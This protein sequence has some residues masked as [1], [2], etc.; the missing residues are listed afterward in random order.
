MATIIVAVILI[1]IITII[2]V[3]LVFIHKRDSRKKAFDLLGQ[4]RKMKSEHDLSFSHQEVLENHII[5]L[6][7]RK[8]K[9]LILGRREPDKYDSYVIDI[10]RLSGCTIRNIFNIINTS[11]IKRLKSEE[12]LEKIRLEFEFRDKSHPVGLS[13]YDSTINHSGEMQELR[14]KA[15]QWESILSNQIGNQWMRRA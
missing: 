15:K 1:C 9:L 8:R 7:E 10:N 3:G 6:D 5:G 4:F 13:F 11:N 12:H 2:S 14:Q